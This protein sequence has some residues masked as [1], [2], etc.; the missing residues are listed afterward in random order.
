MGAKEEMARV[1]AT[2]LIAAVA[3]VHAC[4]NGAVRDLPG[5]AV[6]ELDDPFAG[7]LAVTIVIEACLPD[8][9]AGHG[10]A[11]GVAGQALFCR[12]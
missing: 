3:D 6:S 1:H 10:V 2:P 7:Q 11:L 5:Q 8:Q 9:A 4:R 12:P